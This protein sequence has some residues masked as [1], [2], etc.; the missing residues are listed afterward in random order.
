MA[1]SSI[2]SSLPRTLLP[3]GALLAAA[4]PAQSWWFQP[5]DGLNQRAPASIWFDAERGEPVLAGGQARINTVGGW[6]YVQL[7]GIWGFRGGT[8]RRL[9]G[10][11]P[12]LS[13]VHLAGT[14]AYDPVRRRAVRFFAGR[15]WEW[16]GVWTVDHGVTAALAGCDGS[17]V[18]DPARG[19]VM[20]VTG[21]ASGT[22]TWHWDGSIWSRA[23]AAR[24]PASRSGAGLAADP[25]AGTVVLFGGL[26]ASLAAFDDTWIWDGATWS[27]A[28]VA[29]PP[30]TRGSAPGAM[31]HDPVRDRTMMLLAGAAWEWDGARWSPVAAPT[32]PVD[33]MTFDPV[34][35]RLIA[36][37]ESWT[38]GASQGRVQSF[39]GLRWH[40]E[41]RM[42][43][44]ARGALVADPLRGDAIIVDQ[45]SVNGDV[46]VFVGGSVGWTRSSSGPAFSPR[47]QFAAAFDPARDRVV[48]FGG[49]D[50][51]TNTSLGDT[52]TYD[53]TTGVWQQVANTGPSAR[54][55]AAMH[56]DPVS[57]DVILFGGGTG[58]A[59]SETWRWDGS[60]WSQPRP[61]TTPPARAFALMTVDGLGGRLTMA[62]GSSAPN[63]LW[64]WTGTDWAVQPTPPIAAG[65]SFEALGGDPRL[66][67]L[68][69]K[70]TS[71]YFVRDAA[72]WSELVHL[73]QDL[74]AWLTPPR[75]VF[76]ASTGM[77]LMQGHEPTASLWTLSTSRSLAGP[78]GLGC[79]GRLGEPRLY[80]SRF[81]SLG[82]NDFALHLGSGL[83]GSVAV[84]PLALSWPFGS[85]APCTL[86]IALVGAIAS[87]AF[88]LDGAGHVAVPLAIPAVPSLLGQ[89]LGAQAFV[90]DPA[91]AIGGLLS[92]SNGVGLVIGR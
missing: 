82:A 28:T 38:L 19:E 67:I 91:G 57:G 49:F 59:A 34:R 41:W 48:V 65:D 22:E 18:F 25:T 69:L 47:W 72:G 55:G 85:G 21:D 86:Q 5:L 89:R 20:L 61:A 4:L 40:V 14:F 3:V 31:A 64:E 17:L 63:D 51:A 56:R 16:D 43:P 6:Q 50:P 83:P 81:P 58:A 46:D 8:F 39:D 70:T 92:A 74:P 2:R 73:P 26:D 24:S 32:G 90:L 54:H 87:P 77:L 78:L 7:P 37:G 13:Q 9:P 75:M 27:Q 42:V 15:T 66:G 88:A 11:F 76:E 23:T 35:G 12:R 71:S 80:A 84:M 60:R 33:T 79:P 44:P 68:L 36:Y 45:F 30:A 52:W 10:D 1:R 53:R 62:K 29:A